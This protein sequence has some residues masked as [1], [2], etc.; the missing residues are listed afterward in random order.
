ME[1]A[2]SAFD[3]PPLPLPSF[4]VGHNAVLVNEATPNAIAAAVVH[5]YRNPAVAAAIGEAARRT[6]VERFHVNAQMR[7]YHRLYTTLHINNYRKKKS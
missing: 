1:E 6:V 3:A 5:L 2:P 4:S 7:K